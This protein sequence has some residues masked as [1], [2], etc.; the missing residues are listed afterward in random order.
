MSDS[1]PSDSPPDIVRRL[2]RVV[3]RELPYSAAEE[4]LDKNLAAFMDGKQ[5]GNKRGAW[6]RWVRFLHYCA[7]KQFSDFGLVVESAREENG[8]VFARA[9]WR[10]TRG[11]KTEVSQIS[12]AAY[13]VRG[14]K[15]VK[16]WTHRKNY[17]FI[18]GN[19]IADFR[20]AFW[21]LLLRL[22][23]WRAPQK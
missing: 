2:L 3:G 5:L 1:L 7:E 13:E 6:F 20:P 4:L 15:I 22:A 16:I 21:F 8:I 9:T 14:D 18:H 12:E 10:G 19:R 17:V 11:G 23:L